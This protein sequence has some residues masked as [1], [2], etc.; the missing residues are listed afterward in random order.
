[1]GNRGSIYDDNDIKYILNEIPIVVNDLTE[2]MKKNK[3]IAINNNIDYKRNIK[4]I[5]IDVTN[6]LF[7]NLPW[8]K[9]IIDEYITGLAAK[10]FSY[11]I[12]ECDDNDKKIKDNLSNYLFNMFQFINL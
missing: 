6:R 5:T 12:S 8:Y 10:I 11:N 7:N 1:M 3:K 2:F 9:K 4:N